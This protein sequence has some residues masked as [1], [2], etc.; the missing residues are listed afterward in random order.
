MN[1]VD[2]GF[3]RDSIRRL[4]ATLNARTAGMETS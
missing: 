2:E 3:V 1:T 4:D